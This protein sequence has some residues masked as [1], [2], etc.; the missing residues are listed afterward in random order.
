MTHHGLPLFFTDTTRD[1]LGLDAM[2]KVIRLCR[3]FGHLENETAIHKGAYAHG[4]LRQPINSIATHRNRRKRVKA[5]LTPAL[6][7]RG[8]SQ[9]RNLNMLRCRVIDASNE[10]RRL[11]RQ[12]FGQLKRTLGFGHRNLGHDQGRAHHPWLD[13]SRVLPWP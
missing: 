3:H 4:T 10:S 7:S 9:V 12:S 8:V 6:T 5:N 2:P 1:T 13:K 11:V